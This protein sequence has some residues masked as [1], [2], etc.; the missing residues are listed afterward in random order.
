[1]AY[2]KLSTEKSLLNKENKKEKEKRTFLIIR[3]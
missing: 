3:V 1:M 2:K